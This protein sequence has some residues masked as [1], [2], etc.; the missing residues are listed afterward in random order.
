MS[1]TYFAYGANLDVPAM[2]ARC[3]GA[4]PLQ[5]AALDGHRLV[6]MREGWLSITPDADHRVEGLLWTL[7]ASH[8]AALD[9]YEEVAEDLYVH[10]RRLVEAS[11]GSMIEALVYIGTNSGPGSLNQEYAGRVA[12]AALAVLGADTASAIRSLATPG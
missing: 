1:V 10:D 9:V 12:R 2:Q 4:I 11:D 3:P 7:E 6:S 5:T 8:L